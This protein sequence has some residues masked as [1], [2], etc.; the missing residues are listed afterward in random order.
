MHSWFKL[1]EGCLYCENDRDMLKLC[2]GKQTPSPLLGEGWKRSIYFL[3]FFQARLATHGLGKQPRPRNLKA[4]TLCGFFCGLYQLFYF[5]IA[6]SFSKTQSASLLKRED[7][8][9][10]SI[11]GSPRPCPT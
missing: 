6:A 2:N 10:T 9:N 1:Q 8:L 5:L 4:L 3:P 7:P 11:P